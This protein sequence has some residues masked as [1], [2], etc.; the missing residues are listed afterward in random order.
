[1]NWLK[2]ST[3][4]D[5]CSYVV[6]LGVLLGVVFAFNYFFTNQWSLFY[7]P[8]GCLGCE[9]KWILKIDEY[10]SR[11][12]CQDVG[13]AMQEANIGRG[14]TFECGHRCKQVDATGFLCKETVD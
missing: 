13:F 2:K 5:I 4:E 3:G 10:G 8:E 11:E 9:E 12:E 7:Y 1:M 14:D 6:G